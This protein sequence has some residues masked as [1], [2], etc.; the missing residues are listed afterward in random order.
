[1]GMYILSKLL[2]LKF[3]DTPNDFRAL[4]LFYSEE[5]QG[6]IIEETFQDKTLLI[7]ESKLFEIID[8]A[9]KSSALQ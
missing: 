8:E 3:L 2:L 1:M 6:Y 9:Y 7:K 4:W 5:E